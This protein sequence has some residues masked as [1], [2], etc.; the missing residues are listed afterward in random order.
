MPVNTHPI[1]PASLD[2]QSIRLVN[3]AIDE[4]LCAIEAAIKSKQ[5]TR[6]AFVNAD[7]VNIAARDTTYRD[8]LS[9]MDWVFVDGIG[10][11]IAGKILGQPVRDNVNGTD[12]FPRMC[13]SLANQGRSIYLLGGQPGI[14]EAAAAWAKSRFPG[15]V[16]AGIQH[17]YFKQSENAAV[18]EN[19]R[20]SQPDVLLV[21]LG[22]PRQEAWINA[23]MQDTGA[24]V[25]IGVGGL[26][27]YYSGNIPRA[28]LWMR[29]SGLEWVFR[30]TQEPARLWKRY[31][32]GNFTFMARISLDWLLSSKKVQPSKSDPASRR[33]AS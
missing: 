15:L 19:I 7:C 9:M 23:H 17:G 18:F 14:A 10:M 4:A 24:T 16:I 22:A 31:L 11:R 30:L 21:G 27:D 3:L 26:F 25:A 2:I 33:T 12:L 29:K 13:Q 28:P 32:I 8:S 5:P 20:S 6:V 1:I